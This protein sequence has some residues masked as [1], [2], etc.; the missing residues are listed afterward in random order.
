MPKQPAVGDSGSGRY[1]PPKGHDREL[2]CPERRG[3]GKRGERIHGN[4]GTQPSHFPVVAGVG[5]TAKFEMMG[6]LSG[7]SGSK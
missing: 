6:P 2:A 1:T 4:N 5:E 7:I 3:T